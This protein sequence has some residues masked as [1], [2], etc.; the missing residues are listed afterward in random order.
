MD[1]TSKL[2]EQAIS[3]IQNHFRGLSDVHR[4]AAQK[5]KREIA[6]AVLAGGEPT[7]EFAAEAELRGTTATGL[8]AVIAEKP[9]TVM[10]RE[11]ERQKILLAIEAAMSPAQID[12]ILK[13]TGIELRDK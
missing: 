13:N 10:I 6:R 11:L 5:T 2:R 9:D 8:A 3:K 7:A 12:Q 4:D 1:P